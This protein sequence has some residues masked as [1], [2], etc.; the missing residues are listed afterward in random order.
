MCETMPT[1][2]EL[3]RMLSALALE[4]DLTPLSL[5]IRDQ[6]R[7]V[8]QSL[9][10]A[11]LPHTAGDRHVRALH[12]ALFTV[13]HRADLD[14]GPLRETARRIRGLTDLICPTPPEDEDLEDSPVLTPDEAARYL[15]LGKL[16]VTNPA[17]RVRYLVKKKQLRS[18]Q[19]LGRT[20][21]QRSDLDEY[22]IRHAA[23]ERRAH[24]R[25]Q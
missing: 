19:V 2:D 15:G 25:T 5:S 7:R 24:A 18:I 1:P 14:S 17:E 13:T 21:F 10:R 6:A 22:L 3:R 12:D 8:G 9:T 11:A 23:R 16:G 4:L 20:A